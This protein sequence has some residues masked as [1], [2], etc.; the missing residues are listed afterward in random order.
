MFINPIVTLPKE[1][2]GLQDAKLIIS[3]HIDLL[4][5]R[6]FRQLGKLTRLKEDALKTAIDLIL[7]LNPKPGQSINTGVGIRY[8]R[9]FSEKIAG[10]W[11]VELNTDSILN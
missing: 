6:D 1:T 2:D 9:C 10:H 4:A 8:S 3:N 5:N 11:Q 7:T